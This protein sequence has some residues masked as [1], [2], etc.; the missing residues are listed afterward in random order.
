MLNIRSFIGTTVEAVVKETL[1]EYEIG[2][3]INDLEE[4]VSD[5]K[6]EVED[7]N[8]SNFLTERDLEEVLSKEYLNDFQYDVESKIEEIEEATDTCKEEMYR[9]VRQMEKMEAMMEKYETIL[10]KITKKFPDLLETLDED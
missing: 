8:S 6:G 3:K 9:V 5:L 7:L 2:V 4:E 1:K 10:M